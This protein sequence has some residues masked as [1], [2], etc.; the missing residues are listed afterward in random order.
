MILKTINFS[1]LST[2]SL[3]ETILSLCK[4]KDIT[5]ALDWLDNYAEWLLKSNKNLSIEESYE[6]A[7]KNLGYYAI[8][9]NIS[10]KDYRLLEEYMGIYHPFFKDP[11]KVTPKQAFDLGYE[12]ARKFKGNS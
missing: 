12:E 4:S 1:S 2:W 9:C 11:F 5:K 3:I 6:V 7:K 8:S 10:E